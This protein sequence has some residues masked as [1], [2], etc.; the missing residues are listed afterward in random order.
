M[1]IFVSTFKNVEWDTR[2]IIDETLVGDSRSSNTPE[3]S[4][5]SGEQLDLEEF[6]KYGS[7]LAKAYPMNE[8]IRVQRSRQQ[9]T[10][11]IL[12]L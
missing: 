4:S 5:G 1:K 10:F 6:L 12:Q 8:M 9:V 11:F 2:K 3:M 7:D